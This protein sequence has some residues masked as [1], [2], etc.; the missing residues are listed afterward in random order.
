MRLFRREQ[1][2]K[3]FA[4]LMLKHQAIFDT[5]DLEKIGEAFAFIAIETGEWA[6]KNPKELNLSNRI[7]REFWIEDV[8]QPECELKVHLRPTS[9]SIHVRE[10]I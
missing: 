8:G 3:A 5:N 9:L 6:D 10:V 4:N 1:I 7:A 2:K